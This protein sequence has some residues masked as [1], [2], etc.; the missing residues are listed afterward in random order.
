MSSC[1]WLYAKGLPMATDPVQRIRAAEHATPLALDLAHTLDRLANVPPSTEAPYLT[2]NLDWR[3]EG[4]EPGRIPAPEPK[5]SERRSR[6]ADESTSYR[7]SWETLRRDLDE[8]IAGY[9][10]RGA[11]FDS[12]TVDLE[13][14]GQYLD[15]ELDPAAQGVVIVAC[16]AQKVFEP[17]PLTVPVSTGFA[18]GPIPSLLEL[19]HAGHDFPPYA[20]LLADQRDAFLWIMERQT[21]ARG[22]RLEADSYPRKTQQ[23]GWSQ[24]RYQNRADERVEAFARTIAEETRRELTEG[25]AQI[26][27]F[28]L[29][30]DEVMSSALDA[31]FHVSVKERVLE[32][33]RLPIDASMDDIAAV[34]EPLV[35]R[36]ERQ[37]ER[38]AVQAVSDGV[39]AGGR[40]VAG[41]EDTLTALETGQVM[42]LVMNDDF[43]GPSWADFTFPVYGAGDPPREHPAAG[44]VANVIPVPLTDIATRLA[45]QTGADVELVA[46]A[47][48]V[49][50]D[51]EIPDADQPAPRSKAARALDAMGGIG[52]VLRFALDEGQSTADR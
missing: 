39:G 48:P 34:A 36:Q 13:R 3:P 47:V 49:G 35:E 20:V 43:E 30:A 50:E 21:W 40:G 42:T 46:T 10:P 25:D 44:D 29:A 41:P 22:V 45:L 11:A 51:D 27:Y 28:I 19:I 7:P 18:L 23:G 15:N 37:H 17:V 14:I 8:A 5:R 24:K 9:G 4:S 52:A 31:A 6:A 12:L 38:D 33:V 32:V 26:P 16:D 1:A 2:V